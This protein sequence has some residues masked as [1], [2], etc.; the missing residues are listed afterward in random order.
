MPTRKYV[1]RSLL[2][3]WDGKQEDKALCDRIMISFHRFQ[4][5]RDET[6]APGR[7]SYRRL[8]GMHGGGGGT[9][10]PKFLEILT[11]KMNDDVRQHYQDKDSGKINLPDHALWPYPYPNAAEPRKVD[12]NMKGAAFMY[13]FCWHGAPPFLLW[14]R[15]YMAEF[16]YNLQKNDPK[17]DHID[18]KD[19]PML[20]QGSDA[21][22]LPYW[23][24][25]GWDGLTLPIQISLEYYTVK[26][27]MWEK[28]G[29]PQGSTFP[30]PFHRWFAPVS[31]EQQMSEAF[32]PQMTAA[33]T[34]TRAQAF[35]DVTIGHARGAYDSTWTIHG[36]DSPGNMAMSDIVHEAIANN[37]WN[38]FS[39][40]AFGGNSSIENPHNK[41]HNHIGGAK[42]LGGAQGS[43]MQWWPD[44]KERKL[45]YV[46]TMTQNQSAHDPIFWLHHSNVERQLMSWQKLWLPD[47]DKPRSSRG[48]KRKQAND[49]EVQVSEPSHP[50][51]PSEDLLNVVLYPWT[52][53]AKL[54]AGH[55]SYNSENT[56]ENNAKFSDWWNWSNLPYEYDRLIMPQQKR[57]MTGYASFVD[58]YVEN[59]DFA[60]GEY[61]LLFNGGVIGTQAILTAQTSLC[62]HCATRNN[63]YVRFEVSRIGTVTNIADQKNMFALMCNGTNV[64]ITDIEEIGSIEI[65]TMIGRENKWRKARKRT[66]QSNAEKKK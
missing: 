36:Q 16:E 10:D 22:G 8:V 53:P 1:R 12:F 28:N 11:S 60:S 21:L 37:N 3:I 54:Y 62:A 33:N 63:P 20:H 31:L 23:P 51:Q 49:D 43:E 26:T 44:A 55:Q 38:M 45:P 50:S 24:W 59:K 48:D 14:H 35:S 52:K 46:G 64:A 15:A 66:Q 7:V 42:I 39:T 9:S 61:T 32:P 40:V 19:D 13:Q 25:E 30:N 4:T 6:K 17:F 5:G 34:T 29:F 47:G 58:V 18:N 27:D 57:Q 2:A 65:S 41:F 56:D